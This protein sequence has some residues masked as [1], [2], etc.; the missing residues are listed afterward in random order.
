[1]HYEITPIQK[2]VETFTSQNWKFSDKNLWY[3]YI[4]EAVLTNT[5]NLYFEQKYE[6]NVYPFKPQFCYIKL[7]LKRVKFV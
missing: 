1:M 3:F 7:G 4:T 2:D 6:K 5:H